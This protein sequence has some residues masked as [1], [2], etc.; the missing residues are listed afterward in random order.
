[1]KYGAKSMLSSDRS[2]LSVTE[3]CF[4]SLRLGSVTHRLQKSVFQVIHRER[5]VI[6]TET[7]VQWAGWVSDQWLCSAARGQSRRFS[8]L[9]RSCQSA[10]GGGSSPRTC[11][12]YVV[13]ER[14]CG[15]RLPA[16]FTPVRTCVY[17]WNITGSLHT[18][19]GSN[20]ELKLKSQ[21]LLL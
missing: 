3:T 12:N 6:Q 17:Q 14:Y 20:G 13:L 2:A 19:V 5:W 18:A 1:M 15:N 4:S 21:M 9:A 16:S 7:L 8:S 11:C 10:G